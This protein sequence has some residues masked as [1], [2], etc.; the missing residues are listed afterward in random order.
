MA[1][2]P[3]RDLEELVQALERHLRLLQEYAQKAF[4]EG[5]FDYGGEIAGKLRL[6]VTKFGS[7]RPLLLDLMA[8]TDISPLITLGGPPIKPMP[9][10]PG[11]G[12]TISLSQYLQLGAIGIRVPNGDFVMLNKTQFIRA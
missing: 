1:Q 7:N 3:S 5:N 8:K 11:P 2:T 6:L 9:G 4:Q 10:Q 12:D